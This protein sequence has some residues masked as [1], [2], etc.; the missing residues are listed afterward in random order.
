MN[1]EH[2]DVFRFGV[3]NVGWSDILYFLVPA[4]IGGFFKD[5]LFSPNNELLFDYFGNHSAWV[6]S[7]EKMVEKYGEVFV[8]NCSTLSYVRYSK[9]ETNV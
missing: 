2:F 5:A 1:K 6:S 7:I 9:G 3:K 8:Y 4:E